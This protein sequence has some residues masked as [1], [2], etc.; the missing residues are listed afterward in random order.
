[1]IVSSAL[2]NMPRA[3][4]ATTSS[5]QFYDFHGFLL[6]LGTIFSIMARMNPYATSIQLVAAARSKWE[7]FQQ[8][9]IDEWQKMARN[10]Q[11][12]VKSEEDKESHFLARAAFIEY[13]IAQGFETQVRILREK[14]ESFTR[15]VVVPD[16]D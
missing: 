8:P 14:L 5:P 16:I 12:E 15:I 1:M 2:H 4:N 11:L 13:A 7:E 9:F 10:S 6:W 3:S